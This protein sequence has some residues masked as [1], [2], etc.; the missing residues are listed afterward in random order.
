MRPVPTVLSGAERTQVLRVASESRFADK[1][2][3]RIV[4]M[5]ADEGVYVASESSL[6]RMLRAHA[7]AEHRGR[8]KTP[9][10]VRPATT[11]IAMAPLQVGC[12]DVIDQPATVT[13]QCFHPCLILGLYSRKIVG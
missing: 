4:P 5:L 6:A 1:P 9:K 8:A 3:V 7:Q 13:G 11:H 12:W 2:P 10:P